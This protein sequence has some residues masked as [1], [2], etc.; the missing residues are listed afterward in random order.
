MDLATKVQSIKPEVR[1]SPLRGFEFLSGYGVFASPFESGDVLA[2]RVFPINDFA[3]Y[4]TVWH[5]SPEGEWS[6]YVDSPRMDIACPRYYGASTV[7]TGPARISLKWLGPMQLSIEMDE[8][9]LQWT[10]SMAASPLI[11]VM[12][13]IS[14]SIPE[15]LWRAP[16]LLR[17]FERMGSVLFDMGDVSLSGKSPNGQYSIMMPRQMFPITSATARLGGVDFGKPV[18]SKQN[19][20]I[21]E[22]RLPARPVFAIGQGYFKIGDPEEYRKTV[23]ELHPVPA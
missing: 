7:W 13:A 1:R 4:H 15:P 9:S 19:P 17:A 22:L 16:L 5:R 6:I 2:L 20:M 11:S 14:R 8:P 3:P 12:N 10:I 21:G 23:A 18:R